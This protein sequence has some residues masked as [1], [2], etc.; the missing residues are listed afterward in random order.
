LPARPTVMRDG[1]ETVGTSTAEQTSRTGVSDETGLLQQF[2]RLLGHFSTYLNTQADL[3]KLKGR[4]A[5]FRVEVEIVGILVVAG[6][7]LVAITLVTVGAAGGFAELL[8][9]K[10]WLGNIVAGVLLLGCVGLGVWGWVK[11]QG[12]VSYK[13]TVEKYEKRKHKQGGNPPHE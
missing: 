3:L 2:S 10:S 5:L 1:D 11:R 13:R 9:G 4:L 8:G 7:M 6:A 12:A